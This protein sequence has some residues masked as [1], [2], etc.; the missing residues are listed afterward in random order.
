MN[1]DIGSQAASCEVFE[2]HEN[3]TFDH[4]LSLISDNLLLS[5]EE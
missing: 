5:A 4:P 2:K 1:S 3:H